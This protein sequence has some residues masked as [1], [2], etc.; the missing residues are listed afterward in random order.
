MTQ[1]WAGLTPESR[2]TCVSGGPGL[3][4]GHLHI[5]NIPAGQEG[6][7]VGNEPEF[8]P[9]DLVESI[10]RKGEADL[11]PVVNEVGKAG[12]QEGQFRVISRVQYGEL[13]KIIDREGSNG[14]GGLDVVVVS[15]PEGRAL[16]PGQ[17]NGRGAQ[18]DIGIDLF[19]HGQQPNETQ[20][21][22]EGPISL[23]C[24]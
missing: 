12:N 24:G 8:D 22:I 15:E 2:P 16:C 10:R 4:D 19:A 6:D 11:L 9:D 21:A 7:V 14:F 13:A 18:P 5:V 17:V 3:R 23:V 20:G 1:A